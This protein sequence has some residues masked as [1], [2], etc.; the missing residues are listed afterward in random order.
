MNSDDYNWIKAGPELPT[1][2]ELIW[3][4]RWV[5]Q[6]ENREYRLIAECDLSKLLMVNTWQSEFS[7][8]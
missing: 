4:V 1:R 3:L 8:D 6:A 5:E 7:G 2:S